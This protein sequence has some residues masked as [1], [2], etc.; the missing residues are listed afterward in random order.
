MNH[1][2]ERLFRHLRKRIDTA[3]DA[4]NEM[5]VSSPLDNQ[6]EPIVVST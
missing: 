1:P 5:S 3:R 6:V 4:P 2:R